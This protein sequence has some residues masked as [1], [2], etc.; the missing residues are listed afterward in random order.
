VATAAKDR[1]A[2]TERTS[3]LFSIVAISGFDRLW[4]APLL[5][6]IARDLGAAVSTVTLAATAHFLCF[7]IFQV[8]HGRLSDRIG[9]QQALRIAL[10]VMGL[11]DLACAMAPT[12]GL[13]ILV[14][15]IAGA[16]S[17][18]LVPGALV[19]IAEQPP[20]RERSRRQAVI[21]SAL[22]VGT[23]ISAVTGLAADP[24]GWR[25]VLVVTAV[26]SVGLAL[27][28]GPGSTRTA[29]RRPRVMEVVRRPGVRYIALVGIPEGA[30]VFGFIVFFPG[31]IEHLGARPTVAALSTAVVG[32]G[33]ILGSF[34]VRRV[35]GRLDDR[36][37]TAGGAALLTIGYVFAAVPSVWTLFIAAALAGFGQSALHAVLQRRAAEAA[38]D[39]RGVSA[40]LFG[41]GIF[42]GA[43]LAALLGAG[44]PG[45]FTILFLVSA[46]CS[47]VAGAAA[48]IRPTMPTPAQLPIGENALARPRPAP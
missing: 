14:R 41:L 21:V 42:G 12:V 27:L 22:G 16:A 30:A 39:A 15:A 38:P 23:A 18:G 31:G 36:I 9:R 46:L 33:M 24:G 34:L 44:L 10:L 25:V 3:I 32:V 17:G 5:A 13:L 7:G 11:A 8:S 37:L 2:R 29:V 35:T 19:V 47:V 26:L 48:S 6:P 28:I 43:G 4:V 1:G 40:A 45:R 20:G